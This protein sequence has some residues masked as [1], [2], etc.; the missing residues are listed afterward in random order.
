[1]DPG[2]KPGVKGAALK[3]A[4]LKPADEAALER[5]MQLYSCYVELT[6]YSLAAFA[7]AADETWPHIPDHSLTLVVTR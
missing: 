3:P 2:P 1:M 7:E 5:A 6:S 4:A